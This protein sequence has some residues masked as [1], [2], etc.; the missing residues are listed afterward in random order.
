MGGSVRAL[1]ANPWR[2]RYFLEQV[3]QALGDEGIA[4][5]TVEHDGLPHTS[6]WV[7]IPTSTGH[8]A[9]WDGAELGE[10]GVFIQAYELAGP[11]GT[12]VDFAGDITRVIEGGGVGET[13]ALT[14][15]YL[16]GPSVAGR[17]EL[18]DLRR[19]LDKALAVEERQLKPEPQQPSLVR[20]DGGRV[21]PREIP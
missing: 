20:R 13:V 11:F 21:G 16:A 12:E 17:D 10:R 19:R 6:P 18:R 15:S 4:G 5:V 3:A 1:L 7:R 8:V 2:V 9:V 14:R